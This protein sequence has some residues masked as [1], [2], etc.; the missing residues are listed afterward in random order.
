MYV[1]GA[2]TV[3][4]FALHRNTVEWLDGTTALELVGGGVPPAAAR[5]RWA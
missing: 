5:R 1:A 4:S 3:D 2:T